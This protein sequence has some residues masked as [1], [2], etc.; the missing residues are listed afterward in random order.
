V[1]GTIDQA[2]SMRAH[3]DDRR[4]HEGQL[5][6]EV[7]RPVFLEEHLQHVGNGSWK[8]PKGPTRFGP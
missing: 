1:I 4:Q 8:M 5:V 2:I 7:G 6:D 3:G